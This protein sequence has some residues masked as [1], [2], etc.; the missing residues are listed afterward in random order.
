[1]RKGQLVAVLVVLG[2]L[3]SIHAITFPASLTVVRNI[4]MPLNIDSF[5]TKT[6]CCRN[7]SNGNPSYNIVSLDGFKTLSTSTTIQQ[8]LTP[9][10]IWLN[11]FASIAGLKPGR[12]G[13]TTASLQSYI[14]DNYHQ[15]GAK[16]IF[17][18]F[19]DECPISILKADPL[20]VAQSITNM[21]KVS[22]LDGVSL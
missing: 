2:S 18:A 5:Y 19:G 22:Q 21:V 1:M 12:G 20:L 10:G 8:S 15:H 6:G 14:L 3:C 11:A 7:D 9:L 4:L 13:N 16:L 17:N